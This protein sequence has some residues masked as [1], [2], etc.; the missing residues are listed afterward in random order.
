MHF[1]GIAGIGGPGMGSGRSLQ[2][3]PCHWCRPVLVAPALA[4]FRQ[5][6]VTDR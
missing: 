5:E 4:A 2:V 1:C 3:S 6:L